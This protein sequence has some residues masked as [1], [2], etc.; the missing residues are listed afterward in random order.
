MEPR[1]TPQPFEFALDRMGPV[2]VSYAG[3]GHVW[4]DVTAPRLGKLQQVNVASTRMGGP[5]GRR[6]ASFR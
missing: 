3:V 4:R 5:A 1:L 2:L 6:S